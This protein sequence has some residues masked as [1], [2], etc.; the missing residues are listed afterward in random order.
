MEAYSVQG[1]PVFTSDN[2]PEDRLLKSV[3]NGEESSP[4]NDCRGCMNL[5]E[6]TVEA[7]KD[8]NSL[9][10]YNNSLLI[11]SN[12]RD[13]YTGFWDQVDFFLNG[14]ISNGVKYN[15]Q[16]NPLG[17]APIGGTGPD[18]SPTRIL[19]ISKLLIKEGGIWK[20]AINGRIVSKEALKRFGLQGPSLNTTTKVSNLEKA[21]EQ[22]VSNVPNTTGP[23]STWEKIKQIIAIAG[24]WNIK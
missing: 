20:W 15:M 13:P 1:T 18:V 22:T 24:Q 10:N 21:F 8:Q 5:P 4:G 12:N 17:P 9:S 14:G 6:F 16:G 11:I 2:E 19:K 3:V 23:I 7:P